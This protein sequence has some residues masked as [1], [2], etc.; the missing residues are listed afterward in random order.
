MWQRNIDSNQYRSIEAIENV[1]KPLKPN[2]DPG[3]EVLVLTDTEH[4]PEVWKLIATA[5]RSLDAHPVVS[6]VESPEM[7][8]Y[9]PPESV[10]TQMKSVDVVVTS[11][12]TAMLHSP[13]GEAAME[14]GVPVIAMDGGITIDM[15]TRGAATADYKE[16]E[17]IEYEIGKHV[18][19]GGSEAHLTSEYG[20]D[21]TLSVEDR[22]SLYREPDP[23]TTPLEIYEKRPGFLAAVFPRGEFNV[24]PDPTTANGTIV[25][26]TTMHYLGRLE[27]PI[28]LEIESGTIT[29]VRGGYQARELERIIEEYGDEDAYKMPTEFSVGANPAARITGCQREDKNMLGA[30]HIGLGT[31]SDVG[32]DIRSK[33]HMDGV[34]ARP[35]LEIDGE[36]K[37][38]NGDIL[39]VEV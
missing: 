4:D 20:T 15:L 8:Y 5:V 21:L 2:V 32:G 6:L 31:N 39:P 3:D 26:D 38:D 23:D 36:V 10:A 17:R 14:A 1:L 12:T 18:F 22:V 27:E 11:T 30:I 37:I 35:T 16:I 33:L 25:F 24:A 13:A 9:N 34:I 28:E 7:D 19:E 29:E